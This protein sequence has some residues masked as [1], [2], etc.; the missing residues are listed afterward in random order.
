MLL[1]QDTGS[2]KELC[3]GRGAV[4]NTGFQ[5]SL[6]EVLLMQR[7]EGRGDP[8]G[9]TGSPFLTLSQH[10]V[11]VGGAAVSRSSL[12]PLSHFLV[13]SPACWEVLCPSS[14]YESLPQPRRRE[15]EDGWGPPRGRPW[16]QLP[17]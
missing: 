2:A 5:K 1:L 9:S 4:L 14:E 15:M 11:G 13:Y 16:P 17:R 7:L 8:V 10:H 3:L 12:A 6:V